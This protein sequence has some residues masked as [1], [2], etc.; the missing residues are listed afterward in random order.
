MDSERG[1]IASLRFVNRWFYLTARTLLARPLHLLFR[2]EVVNRDAVPRNGPAFILPN[3]VTLFDPIWLYSS[4]RRP[5]YLVATEELFRSWFLR[6][7]IRWFGAFPKRKATR[8]LHTVKSMFTVLR[9]GGIVGVYPEGVRTWDGTNTPIVP[10]IARI[11]RKFK[12]PVITCRFDGGYFSWPRWASR[13]RR[14]PVRI[15]F[16][17]LY[18][19]ESIPESDDELIRQISERIRIRDYE[20]PS[21][22]TAGAFRGLTEGISRILYRCP[23]CGSLESLRPVLPPRRNRF[24]C[25]SCYSSWKLDVRCNITPVDSSGH[26]AGDGVPLPAMYRQIREMPL[27]PMRSGL[28][29]LDEGERLY[30]ISSP[31][32]VLRER[33][34]PYF[35]PFAFGRLFLTSRRL[36]VHG[37]RGLRLSVPVENL[38]SLSIEPGNKLHFVYTGRLY[39]VV[40]RNTSALKWADFIERLVGRSLTD[41]A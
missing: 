35:R 18:P 34:F 6:M 41:M 13:W 9:S 26:A 40:F 37:R 38:E 3:H 36:M 24:E 25:S 19:P 7:L 14:V 33:K 4:L 10:T 27:V 8:D 30:L 15:I 11:I 17:P 28:V 39:R 31:H 2:L 29:D 20:L 22:R 16:E 1:R 12:V 23:Q 5:V 21:G 32:L